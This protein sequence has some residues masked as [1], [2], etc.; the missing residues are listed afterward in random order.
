MILFEQSASLGVAVVF[1]L[2][3]VLRF[4]LHKLRSAFFKIFLSGNAAYFPAVFNCRLFNIT[5]KEPALM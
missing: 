1:F 4:F 3:V 2:I 5:V